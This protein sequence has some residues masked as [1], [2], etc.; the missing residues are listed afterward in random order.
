[1]FGLIKLAAY[2]FL[3]YAL[4]EFFRGLTEERETRRPWRPTHHKLD[5]GVRRSIQEEIDR[6]HQGQ[7]ASAPQ[8]RSVFTQQSD[9]GTAS[10]VVG[11]G[12]VQR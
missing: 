3:G 1:M 12:V 5:E 4:Y 9:G 10:H 11:R 8:G 7:G 6:R 2:A